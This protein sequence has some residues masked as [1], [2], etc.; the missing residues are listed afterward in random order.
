MAEAGI[1]WPRS[2]LVPDRF[3]S[4]KPISIQREFPPTAEDIAKL[5][6]FDGLL[7]PVESSILELEP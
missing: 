6:E 3:I 7:P 2:I 1:N 5:F 4:H